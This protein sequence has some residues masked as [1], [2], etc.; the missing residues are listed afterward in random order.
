MGGSD[1]P[2]GEGIGHYF[3]D[4]VERLHHLATLRDWQN[5][6][7]LIHPLRRHQP[8]ISA[9]GNGGRSCV[10][11]CRRE[12][13]MPGF[14]TAAKT[15]HHLKG[16]VPRRLC[17]PAIEPD[18]PVCGGGAASTDGVFAIQRRSI[19]FFSHHQPRD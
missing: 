6:G 2:E 9:K 10:A 16:R 4:Y 12:G 1:P 19:H 15:A 7:V 8:R 3:G 5:S 17:D 13:L 11:H 18:K 14:G